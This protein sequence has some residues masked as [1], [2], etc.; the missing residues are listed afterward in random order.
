M[1]ATKLTIYI[2]REAKKHADAQIK[3]LKNGSKTVFILD[4]E[5]LKKCQKFCQQRCIKTKHMQ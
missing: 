1:K 2:I 5:I 3:Q 4:F